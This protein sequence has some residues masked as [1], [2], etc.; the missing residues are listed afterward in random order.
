MPCSDYRTGKKQCQREKNTEIQHRLQRR[1]RRCWRRERPQCGTRGGCHGHHESG[2][3]RPVHSDGSWRNRARGFRQ[4]VRAT[5]CHRPIEA[6]DR[7]NLKIISCALSCADRRA[8]R[9]ES[10]LPTRASSRGT[11]SVPRTG[12]HPWREYASHLWYRDDA[13]ACH[14]ARGRPTSVRM[15]ST[16][17]P[18]CSRR[19][20]SAAYF[21]VR[22]AMTMSRSSIGRSSATKVQGSFS[23]RWRSPAPGS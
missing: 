11:D 7:P 4:R 17:C 21:L 18:A 2:S 9:R 19:S 10:A 13:C 23:V 16:L 12:S 1:S 5:K 22:S 3:G 14:A 6:A 20:S 15:V 8:T